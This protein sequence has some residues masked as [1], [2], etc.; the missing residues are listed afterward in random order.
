MSPDHS[1]ASRSTESRSGISRLAQGEL[2][3]DHRKFPTFIKLFFELVY[4]H[5]R[6]TDPV[7]P[8]RLDA[9]LFNDFATF[10]DDQWHIDIVPGHL[11]PKIDTEGWSSPFNPI[12]TVLSGLYTLQ[13]GR[14]WGQLKNMKRSAGKGSHRRCGVAY[15][16]FVWRTLSS[17]TAHLTPMRICVILHED[18][19]ISPVINRFYNGFEA[20][21]WNIQSGVV[22]QGRPNGAKCAHLPQ[23]W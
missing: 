1:S 12:W 5:N 6:S 7:Y 16:A 22:P 11:L 8:H 4:F 18:L 9:I 20:G 14:Q 3:P 13:M 19:E 15:K 10:H 17:G 21:A 2:P 23:V